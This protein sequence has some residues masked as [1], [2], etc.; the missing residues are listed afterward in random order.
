M[1]C[2]KCQKTLLILAQIRIETH[3]KTLPKINVRCALSFPPILLANYCK[4]VSMHFYFN[5]ATASSGSTK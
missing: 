4:I 5:G 1:K 2:V 3:R